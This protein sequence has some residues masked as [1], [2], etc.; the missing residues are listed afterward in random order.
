MKK[1]RRIGRRWARRVFRSATIKSLPEQSSLGRLAA[2]LNV[3]MASVQHWILIGL[4]SAKKG[5]RRIVKKADLV[6]FLRATKRLRGGE[7]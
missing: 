2:M 6:K 7:K 5:N 3:A 1:N 4:R